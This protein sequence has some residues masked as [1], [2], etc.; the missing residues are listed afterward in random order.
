MYTAF[1]NLK[2]IDLE[3]SKNAVLVRDGRIN[4]ARGQIHEEVRLNIGHYRSFQGK[5]NPYGWHL[6]IGN[7]FA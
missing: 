5:E 6:I 7:Q 2:C 3:A 1:A 4:G